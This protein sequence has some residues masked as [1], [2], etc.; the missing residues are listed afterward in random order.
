VI[1]GV[2]VVSATVSWVAAAQITSPDEAQRSAAAPTASL[3]AVPVERRALSANLMLRGELS[4][5][6]ATVI[7]VPALSGAA[8]GA[9]ARV[10]TKDPTAVAEE[11][12]EGQSVVEISGRPLIVLQGALPVFR[13]L[14]V[15]SEGDD[16]EQLE[17]ALARLGHSPGTIDRTFDAATQAAVDALYRGAGYLPLEPTKEQSEKLSTARK[18][19][20]DAQRA[21]REAERSARSDGSTTESE[22]LRL[23]ADVESARRAVDKAKTGAQRSRDAAPVSVASAQGELDSAMA[24]RAA[25]EARLTAATAPGAVDPETGESFDAAA[26]S[27]LEAAAAEA[28]SAVA[29]A[30]KTLGE[31]RIA[32]IDAVVDADAAVLDAEATLKVGS[33]AS[34][35][36]LAPRDSSGREGIVDANAAVAEAVKQ[37]ATLAA[38]TKGLP[39]AEMVFVRSLPRRVGSVQLAR[40]DIAQGELMTVSGSDLAVRTSVTPADRTLVAAGTKV[41]ISESDLDL[42]FS[43]VVRSI[44]DQPIGQAPQE[45]PSDEFANTGPSS[46]NDQQ[47]DRF[48]V[49]I[50][51]GELPDDVD[52]ATLESLNFRI[53]IPVKSTDGEVLAVPLAAL[54]AT[55]DDRVQVEVVVKGSTTRFVEVKKGLAAQGFVE[56]TTTSGDELDEGDQVVVGR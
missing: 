8:E 50:T 23:Q 3:V 30:N 12:T 46:G 31:V 37:V 44:A 35:E 28:R 2:A 48:E 4:F 34:L 22:R 18:N 19:V 51:P 7:A 14:G 1:A 38:E 40:G 24:R 17:E 56:V 11:I 45:K 29:T 15:G 54:S 36:A 13:N 47:S 6:E 5:D 49:V 16:V 20:E 32:A 53:T 33:Q 43:G 21:V 39:Q 27:A 10:V 9:A 25:A 41:T 26:T 42:E 55:G 52:L